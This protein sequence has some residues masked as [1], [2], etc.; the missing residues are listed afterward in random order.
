MENIRKQ[1]EE[2]ATIIDTYIA[3]ENTYML[4]PTR[5]YNSYSIAL[6][7]EAI[8]YV[9][10][11]PL[12]IIKHSC[13]KLDWV[14]YE[15]RKL[16]IADTLNLP[17]HTPMMLSQGKEIFAFPTMS[18]LHQEC[19]WIF[20]HADIDIGKAFNKAALF[21]NWEKKIHLDISYHTLQVQFG[22]AFHLQ[23]VLLSN[24]PRFKH[25]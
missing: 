6:E 24:K 13:E 7:K 5:T 8:Y 20:Q 14:T 9:K 4:L 17:Y 1:A 22:K 3:N 16:I 19:C 2:E 10:Q 18:P 12:E 15:G 21:I 23:N 25:Y 11:T